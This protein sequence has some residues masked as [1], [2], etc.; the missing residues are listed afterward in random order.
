MKDELESGGQKLSGVAELTLWP[1]KAVAPFSKLPW[2]AIF[3]SGVE[4]VLPDIAGVA[5]SPSRS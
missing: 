3:S 1:C 2:K 5:Q 4:A